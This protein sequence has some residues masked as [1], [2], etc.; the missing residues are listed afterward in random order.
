METKDSEIGRMEALARNISQAEAPISQHMENTKKYNGSDLPTPPPHHRGRA[1][2]QPL[3][4]EGA[5][6]SDHTYMGMASN[7]ERRRAPWITDNKRLL[8]V[9]LCAKTERG[10]LNNR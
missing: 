6:A 4:G 3:G 8:G 5:R 9:V 2:G 1:G 10:L 7:P